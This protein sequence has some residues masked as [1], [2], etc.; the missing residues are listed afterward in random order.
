MCLLK[1]DRSEWG[2]KLELVTLDCK[3]LSCVEVDIWTQCG[4]C[5]AISGFY[6]ETRWI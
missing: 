3:V 2:K 6:A 5:K 1:S 4:Y